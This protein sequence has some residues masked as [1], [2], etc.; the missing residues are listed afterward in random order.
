MWVSLIL[1]V[2]LSLSLSSSSLDDDPNSMTSVT[3]L[4]HGL[5]DQIVED[6]TL[7]IG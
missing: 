2:L 3:V 6:V 1:P 7:E 4:A 5:A